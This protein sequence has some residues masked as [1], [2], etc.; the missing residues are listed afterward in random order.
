MEKRKRNRLQNSWAQQHCTGRHSRLKPEIRT[1]SSFIFQETNDSDEHRKRKPEKTITKSGTYVLSNEP[2]GEASIQFDP[3]FIPLEETKWMFEDLEC[4]I[5]W[6]EKNIKVQGQYH[7]QPRLTAWFGDFPYTYSGLTL[8][9]FEWSPLLNVLRERIF[10]KTGLTFN[11][12]LANLY[13]NEKDSV[14]WHSDDEVSLGNKP[15]ICSL[16]F[17]ETRNF[18]MRKKPGQGE[19]YSFSETIKIPLP[20]GSLLVMSGAS[21]QDWQHRV[22]KEYH[23][24]SPRINLTF[25]NITPS[26]S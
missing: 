19:D 6:Q 3:A 7:R 14:D 16:S 4:H 13:R 9:P 25:R 10:E 20:S 12:M 18:E 15:T 24:R 8:Q 22:P 23:S 21:Q 5:P 2:S 1:S 17:G 11:S 26:N